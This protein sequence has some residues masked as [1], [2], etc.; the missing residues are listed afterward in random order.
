MK[1]TKTPSKRAPQRTC[2]A[3]KEVK[4]KREMTRIVRAPDGKIS[5]DP[6][7]RLAGR[8]AYICGSLACWQVGLESKK[9]DYVLKTKIAPEERKRLLAE[10][11]SLIGG[12]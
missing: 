4:N 3:C 8:G 12:G 5:I 7:G 1:Q 10:G 9:L 11:Q 2:V 6:Q